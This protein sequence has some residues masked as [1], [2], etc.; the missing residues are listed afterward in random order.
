MAEEI[1]YHIIQD[2][3]LASADLNPIEQIWG[4]L[5]KRVSARHPSNFYELGQFTFEEWETIDSESRDL[6]HRVVSSSAISCYRCKWMVH[7]VLSRV[8]FV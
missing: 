2:W 5:K 3:P 4:E 7:Q 1:G 8:F 6:I